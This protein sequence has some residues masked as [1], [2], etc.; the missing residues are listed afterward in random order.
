MK[1]A[2]SFTVGVLILSSC[3]YQDQSKPGL[4]GSDNCTGYYSNLNICKWNEESLPIDSI[5]I[6]GVMPLN[7][8]TVELFKFLGKPQRIIP[9]STNRNNCLLLDE[10]VKIRGNYLIYGNT[11]FEQYGEHVI[12]NTIDFEST[13][14]ANG[15]VVFRFLCQ[16]DISSQ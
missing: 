2:K 5:L 15:W 14:A 6:D 3:T 16:S 4:I 9:I 12:V 11:I 8:D 7:T 1:I 13:N 10:D